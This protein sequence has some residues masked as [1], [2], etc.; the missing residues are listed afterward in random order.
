[1]CAGARPRAVPVMVASTGEL[2]GVNILLDTFPK[3]VL[4]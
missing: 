3:L 4:I 2:K 1:L